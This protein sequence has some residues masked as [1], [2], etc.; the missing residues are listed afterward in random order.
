MRPGPRGSLAEYEALHRILV[1][2]GAVDGTRIHITEWKQLA[3]MAFQAG[4]VRTADRH[5]QM[6]EALGYLDRVRDHV[7]L[8]VP[9]AVDAGARAAP[10]ST[11]GRPKRRATT[12]GVVRFLGPPAGAPATA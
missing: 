9:R 5:T 4:T 1:G 8:H 3:I 6:M 2:R 10:G 11:R 12:P 7:V